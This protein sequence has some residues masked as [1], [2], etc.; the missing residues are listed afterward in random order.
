MSSTDSN[1]NNNKQEEKK[2][3]ENV[4]SS[5]SKN[6]DT[7]SVTNNKNT[8]DVIVFHKK[9]KT[10][11]KKK[12]KISFEDNEKESKKNI[13][14]REEVK[15]E[16]QSTP[17][18]FGGFLKELSDSDTENNITINSETDEE[19]F[20]NKKPQ[21]IEKKN[22]RVIDNN[23]RSIST[24]SNY[25]SK[26]RFADLD[27]QEEERRKYSLTK[28]KSKKNFDNN[29]D[30]DSSL[31]ERKDKQMKRKESIKRM[32]SFFDLGEDSD[33]ETDISITT[34][35]SM[36]S[37]IENISF[38]S[39]KGITEM[40]KNLKRKILQNLK[41]GFDI[42]KR[43]TKLLFVV[44][45][46]FFY[47]VFVAGILFLFYLLF[48]LLSMITIFGIPHGKKLFKLS[49]YFLYPFKK[50]LH[51]KLNSDK[52]V[53]SNSINGSNDDNE[54]LPILDS[55]ST[56]NEKKNRTLTFWIYQIL[57][58]IFLF[59]I[60]F[61]FNFFIVCIFW[62]PI[63]SIPISKL[64][65]NLTKII[66]L[67]SFTHFEITATST[68]TSD[69]F[70]SLNEKSEDGVVI[71]KN[72]NE[73]VIQ[74]ETPLSLQYFTKSIFNISIPL[75]NLLPLIP[76]TLCLYY[77]LGEEFVSK[78]SMVIFP[79]SIVSAMPLAIIIGKCV[80]SIVAQTSFVLGAL[81]NATFGS[82]IELIL[83][84]LALQ[85]ELQ[86]VVMQG[87]TGA[88]LA[89]ILLTPGLSMLVGGIKYKQQY[90]NRHSAG[91]SSI[92]LFIAVLGA[93]TP[94]VFYQLFGANTLQ[95]GQCLNGLPY[96][97]TIENDENFITT[98][99]FS[100]TMNKL[101]SN[102][103]MKSLF[104][105]KK[106]MKPTSPVL[107]GKYL[108]NDKSHKI[109]TIYG[110][111]EIN[112]LQHD[113][114]Q[115]LIDNKESN[116][117]QYHTLHTVHQEYITLND[118]NNTFNNHSRNATVFS[119][120]CVGCDMRLEDFM[121][122]PMYFSKVQPLAFTISIVLPLAYFVGLLYSLK[123][124]R[125]LFQKIP[126]KG[127]LDKKDKREEE[128]KKDEHHEEE[129][130]WPIWLS[131]LLLI[132]CTVAYSFIAEIM[133]SALEPAFESLGIDIQFAGLTFL[134]TIP[135]L[136]EFLNAIQFAWNDNVTLSL[137]IGNVA[138][139]QISLIQIPVLVL[140][141]ELLFKNEKMIFTLTFP[142]FNI[143]VVFFAVMMINYISRDGR[144][145]YF[146]GVALVFIYVL[147][148]VG[149]FF[150][151]L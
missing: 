51:F 142:L 148:V 60:L 62:L 43:Y 134:A 109:S 144:S 145:N 42:F 114:H 119:I 22:K 102:S 130:E 87:I 16:E 83:Y 78:Y 141:S 41:Q 110:Q 73:K 79:L 84:F 143:I 67:P 21:I 75:F 9:T 31:D 81:L 98:N 97:R 61:T 135:S 93:F 99:S 53:I 112:S 6:N 65:F 82:I 104:T 3:T 94:A 58:Y 76:L 101:S 128:E 122:D 66:M 2:E 140:F 4:S 7:E 129:V 26:V 146:H 131:V 35:D 123:T 100:T 136:Q 49:F 95:C 147:I 14:K 13:Q 30:S 96:N 103:Y 37:N 139:I 124:H 151:Y 138:A 45:S 1:N 91:V 29:S 105:T 5:L 90:F 68:L 46:Y 36:D 57:F 50:T 72:E 38:F 74:I 88:L 24:L 111:V 18:R 28:R 117:I 149:F 118:N 113:T 71:E 15:L 77:I 19:E 89:A 85:K 69:S 126:K 17:P 120:K 25:G 132:A 32:K 54:T 107:F 10:T 12:K 55:S 125:Y 39:K 133:T 8:E 34:V 121:R 127:I 27:E 108:L 64:I 47:Y 59:P 11:K 115:L 23:E 20:E 80:E 106:K 150:I 92:L 44:F 63:F 137:E 70:D 52:N 33:E 56:T 116:K 40:F 86:G 48:S